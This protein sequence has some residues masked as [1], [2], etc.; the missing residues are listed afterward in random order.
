MAWGAIEECCA[1][2]LTGVLPPLPLPLP[3]VQ[4][5][6]CCKTRCFNTPHNWQLGWSTPVARINA[7]TQTPGTWQQYVLPA[8]NSADSNMLLIQPNWN[9]GYSYG[10]AYMWFLGYRWVAGTA[11]H[12]HSVVAG[13]AW[14]GGIES[15][16]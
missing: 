2:P 3:A 16:C 11:P 15:A 8:Q 12:R 9:P 5:G 14:M 6:A 10:R 13:A 7:T 1:S 4:Q